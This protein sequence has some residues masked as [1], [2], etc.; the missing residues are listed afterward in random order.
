MHMVIDR[1]THRFQTIADVLIDPKRI[2]QYKC[3]GYSVFNIASNNA[4]EFQRNF[5]KFC[6]YSKGGLKKNGAHNQQDNDR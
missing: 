6:F 1:I 3:I 2:L 5:F 4:I